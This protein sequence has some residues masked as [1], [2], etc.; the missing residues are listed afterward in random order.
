MKVKKK[1]V[2]DERLMRLVMLLITLLILQNVMQLL[3]V[4]PRVGL[5]GERPLMLQQ[6]LLLDQ[7]KTNT[8]QPSGEEIMLLQPLPLVPKNLLKLQHKGGLLIKKDITTPEF[9]LVRVVQ[10]ESE[11]LM[12]LEWLMLVPQNLL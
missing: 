9:T 5:R 8:Q 12:Q 2:I 6:H 11:L 3:K 7:K 10:Q 4:K 1:L